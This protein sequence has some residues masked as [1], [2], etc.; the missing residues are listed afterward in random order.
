VLYYIHYFPAVY[1]CAM[2]RKGEVLRTIVYPPVRARSHNMQKTQKNYFRRTLSLEK[3]IVYS[4]ASEWQ[5]SKLE[6]FKHI[7]SEQ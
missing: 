1:L 6:W 5:S 2:K 3:N 7:T 4:S